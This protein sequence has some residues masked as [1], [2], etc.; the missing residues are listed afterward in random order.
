MSRFNRFGVDRRTFALG[1]L[2]AGASRTWTCTTSL[3]LCGLPLRSSGNSSASTWL[4]RD[5]PL[6]RLLTR[7]ESQRFQMSDQRNDISPT[8]PDRRKALIVGAGLI[9]APFLGQLVTAA[10]AQPHSDRLRR[11]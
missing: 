7:P 5:R 11:D 6:H 8:M 3:S 10:Q 2:A 9:A 4:Q 1:S